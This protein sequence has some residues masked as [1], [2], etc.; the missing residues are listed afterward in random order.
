MP[1]NKKPNRLIGEKSPYLL[2]HAHNP[3][4]WYPW[5]EEAFIVARRENKPIFLSIGYSTC[6]WC[7]VMAHESFEDEEVALILNEHYI[8]IKV[9]REERPDIDSIYMKVCQMMAGHG[10]WP[11]SIFMTPDKVPFYAGTYFPKESKYGRP[12]II[13]VLEQLHIKYTKDPEHITD[14]TESVMN[15]LDSTVREKSKHRL[16]KEITD[17]AFQQLGRGFDF[18]YGGFGKAPKFPQPQNLMFLLKYYHST[19]KIAA[20]KM[21]ESTLQNMAAGGIWDHVGYG[22]ARYSTDEKWLVPHFEKMLYDN[23]LLLIVYTEC[24]QIT[25]KTFYKRIAEQIIVFIEREMMNSEGA[26]YSAID[27]DSE[28]VEGKYYVWEDEEIYD[29]LGEDLGE[30]YTTAYGITPYGNFEGKNIPNLIRANLESVAEEFGLTTEDLERQLETGRKKLL[31]EREKRVYPHV[32]DKILTSWNAMM[33]ASLAKAGNVFQ[34]K[35]YIMMAEKAIAFIESNLFTNGKLMA[36]YRDG[37]ANFNAYLDDYAFLSW[38]YLELY[39][40][41]FTLDYLEKGKAL[42]NEMIHSF[43][44]EENGGFF[45]SGKEN[46]KLISNDKEIYDGATPSGNSVASLMLIQYASLTG[47][48][49]FLEKVEEMYFTFFED[50]KRQ[51]SAGAFF[52]QS[53]LLSENPTKEVVVLYE[54][55][56]SWKQ[57]RS[58]LQDKFLPNTVFLIGK[59]PTEFS[60]IAP[61][62]KNYKKLENKTTIYVCQNFT[63]KQPTTNIETAFKN[64]ME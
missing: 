62:A 45:F 1:T 3:V 4:N 60:Q 6:H 57:L 53:L 31:V 37:E 14:V 19:G 33:I 22:F 36:R 43:S 44:D 8:S 50:I 41:T 55:D 38:A 28:G 16:S 13:E 64:I 26:F 56:N 9:D 52:M 5:G 46:E 18:T 32:D 47:E 23:A 11:L 54:E 48:T 51:P 24:Y 21:V 58:L 63:C 12:G 59:D 15:A 35:N 7:H 25:K 20:L 27:A 40:S 2:Q 29:I 39:Q 10:G 30:I 34:N 42:L 49:M 17:Q 61:F